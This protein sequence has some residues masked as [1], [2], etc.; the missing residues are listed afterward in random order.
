MHV[1]KYI[2]KQII[3]LGA[4][5]FYVLTKSFMYTCISSVQ[6][7]T[8]FVSTRLM[9]VDSPPRGLQSLA[10]IID[11]TLK[12]FLPRNGRSLSFRKKFLVHLQIISIITSFK[13]ALNMWYI[14]AD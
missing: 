5:S 1:G 10:L 12:D 3:L 9:L 7:Y 14:C 11:F 6:R 8:C 13:Y 2:L 4:F